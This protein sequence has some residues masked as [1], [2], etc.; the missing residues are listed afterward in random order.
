MKWLGP[1][2]KF[3]GGLKALFIL[4]GG[5]LFG[6]KQ[7]AD[8]VINKFKEADLG[9]RQEQRVNNARI[10]KKWRGIRGSSVTQLPGTKRD[11]NP[12]T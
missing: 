3:L 11:D 4:M 5:F 6:R 10:L 7:G 2:F 1:L 9:A 12:K 8:A